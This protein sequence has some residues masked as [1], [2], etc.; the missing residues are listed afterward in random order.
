MKSKI[1]AIL[2]MTLIVTSGCFF[3]QQKTNTQ[4]ISTKDSDCT[5]EY[6]PVCGVDGKTYSNECFAA[7]QNNVAVAHKG[8][9]QIPSQLTDEER[10]YL[11]W[12]L[13][14][15]VEVGFASESVRHLDTIINDPNN[16]NETA[17]YYEWLDG[18]VRAR[19]IADADGEITAAKDTT[20]YDYLNEQQSEPTEFPELKN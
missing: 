3:T 14:Q 15:R 5:E 6:N 17:Y 1:F 19:I 8:E 2:G 16:G 13:R 18:S 4:S 7:Q 12:L 10:K 11:V 20:G 9:C